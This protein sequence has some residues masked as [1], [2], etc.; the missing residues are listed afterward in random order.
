MLL[1]APSEMQTPGFSKLH[2]NPSNDAESMK[3][4]DNP[5]T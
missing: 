4:T 5:H 3:V 1:V 2:N